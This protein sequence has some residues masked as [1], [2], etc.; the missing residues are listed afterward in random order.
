MESLTNSFLHTVC[1]ATDKSALAVF[2]TAVSFKIEGSEV[3][4]V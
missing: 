3:D 4:R 2:Y 1:F